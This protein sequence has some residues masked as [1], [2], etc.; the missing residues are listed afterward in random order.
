MTRQ[1]SVQPRSAGTR[2]RV[3]SAARAA[4]FKSSKILLFCLLRWATSFKGVS[5]GYGGHAP[6]LRASTAEPETSGLKLYECPLSRQYRH[7]RLTEWIT[8]SARNG[9]ISTS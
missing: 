3:A 8:S 2:S 4:S 1:Y 6:D 7:A 5:A 9:I